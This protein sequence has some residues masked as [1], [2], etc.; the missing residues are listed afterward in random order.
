METSKFKQRVDYRG[1]GS[2]QGEFIFLYF[3]RL[4]VFIRESAHARTRARERAREHTREGAEGESPA[5]P[6]RSTEP[7]LALNLMTR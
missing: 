2:T 1:P 4:Y 3:L 5:D 7:N 6:T